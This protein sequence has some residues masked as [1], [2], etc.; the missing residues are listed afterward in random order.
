MSLPEP[1]EI[2]SPR[3]PAAGGAVA[4]THLALVIVQIA[5][6]AGAVEGK[7]ALN[8]V[9]SGG[10]GVNPVALAMARMAGGALF[11]QVF[12]RAARQLRPVDA[13]DHRRIAGLATLGVVL[14]QTLFLVG[15]RVTTAFAAALLGATIPVFAAAFAVV[16]RIERARATTGVGLALAIAG[17]LW[18]TG[19]GSLDWGAIAIALNCLCYSLYIVL[20]KRVIERLGSLT[21]V[22]WLFTWGA[23]LMA[24]LGASPLVRG[25][26][27]WSPKAWLFVGFFVAGPTIVAYLLNAWAIGRASPTL[28]TVY[29]YLQPV[30]AALMQWL[31]LG[32]PIGSR[33]LGATALIL[34]GVAV[35]A[36]RPAL[37]V[38]AR[39]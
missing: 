18:L 3:P 25:M 24:P 35:V 7:L 22:T 11:F 15:L 39:G 34:A 12:V 10:A 27:E 33:A 8:P 28:V 5:F 1:P 29:I 19:V 9:A 37:T 32:E 23:L 36:T 21:V 4:L 6:A 16:F 2:A 20:S 14:N 26:G 17:V 30:F 13:A 38:P 31:Q